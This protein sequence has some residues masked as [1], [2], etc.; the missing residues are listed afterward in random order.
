MGIFKKAN[1]IYI[2]V[3]DTYTSI[4]GSSYE[5][6][7]EVII[8]A[9]NGDLELVSQKKVIMQGLGNNSDTQETEE[10]STEEK[11]INAPCVVHFR[12]HNDWQGEFGFDW[13]R[14][15]D[16]GMKGDNDFRKTVGY[17]YKNKITKEK[18]KSGNIPNPQDFE[19]DSELLVNAQEEFVQY[20]INKKITNDE[21]YFVPKMTLAK[22]KK[23]ILKLLINKVSAIKNDE[24]LS[25]KLKKYEECF[26]LSD[27]K[28]TIGE[29]IK[30]QCVFEIECIEEFTDTAPVFLEIEIMEKFCGALQIYPNGKKFQK[31]L[32]ITLVKVS[33]RGKKFE[34]ESQ[35]NFL[36][37]VLGQAFVTPLFDREPFDLKNR[38]RDYLLK[39]KEDN[40]IIQRLND[41]TINHENKIIFLIDVDRE[42][43][44][45][46]TL[47]GRK[48]SICFG[49]NI[50]ESTM[51]HEF[52][53][54]LDLL[55]IFQGEAEVKIG[56]NIKK[57]ES[58]V[59]YKLY[60][61]NNI[62]DY[63]EKNENNK[64]SNG[65]RISLFSWQWKVI[66]SSLKNIEPLSKSMEKGKN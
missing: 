30:K 12:P 45:G 3:R 33:K 2:T 35:K 31:K 23:A 7:E 42:D 44:A 40:N 18:Y 25:F 21:K 26:K 8:E 52:L 48:Y 60:S 59:V 1:N 22:G 56:N 9:T 54:S 6:A 66:N 51:T 15:G 47:I 11:V 36:K 62:M 14:T 27:E 50:S 49:G 39:E 13:F 28:I 65:E 46:I 16:T 53:H 17:Y 38:D 29:F 63:L 5:E 34:I 64:Q 41:I 57:I 24:Y 32:D 43:V 4:S 37:K 19:I 61:T 10:Q 58:P 20:K 55:E